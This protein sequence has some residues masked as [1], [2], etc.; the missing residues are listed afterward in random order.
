M[1]NVIFDI[2]AKISCQFLYV[3]KNNYNYL[4]CYH[5]FG[6]FLIVWDT[7]Y[8][9][10]FKFKKNPILS[11]AHLKSHISLLFKELGILSLKNMYKLEL[12]NCIL[13]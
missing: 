12:L 8:D 3:R 6:Y 13:K 9:R 5:Q 4:K 7:N 10:I 11:L 1:S 2:V